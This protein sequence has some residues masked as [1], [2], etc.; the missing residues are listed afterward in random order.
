MFRSSLCARRAFVVAGVLVSMAVSS[1][2]FAGDHSAANKEVVKG[3][4]DGV[5]NAR[6]LDRLG[7]FFAEDY[8]DHRAAPGLP[9]GLEGLRTMMGQMEAAFPDVVHRIDDLV[10]DGDLVAFR[11]TVTGTHSGPMQGIVRRAER[12]QSRR[13]A[14]S[15]SRTAR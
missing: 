6:Q 2:A 3:F 10:A 8:V 1:M 12:P 9:P 13:S 7:E 14:S 5:C 4:I 11:A 15:A